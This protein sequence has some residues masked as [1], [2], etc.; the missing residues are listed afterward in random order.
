MI[1]KQSQEITKAAAAAAVTTQLDGSGT[2]M[3]TG[4]G[5]VWG[6]TDTLRPP[7]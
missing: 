1:L 7:V 2:R 4:L 6:R 5:A 3:D